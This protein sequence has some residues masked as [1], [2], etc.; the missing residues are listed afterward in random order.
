MYTGL[1][2]IEETLPDLLQTDTP[3]AQHLR[4][5]A[6]MLAQ[7]QLAGNLK[8]RYGIAAD[9]ILRE[10]VES[11]YGLVIVG[12]SGTAGRLRMLLLGNVTRQIVENAP[13][14]VL[15]VRPSFFS[16]EDA[17]PQPGSKLR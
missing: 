6:E 11:D 3:V 4:Y 9:E 5:S 2:A 8:L 13:C 17:Q 12:S 10:M 16:W 14:S 7:H 15:V 1:D